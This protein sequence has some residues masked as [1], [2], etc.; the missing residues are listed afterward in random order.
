MKIA[1]KEL[2]F[3]NPTF[4]TAEIG[5]NHNGSVTLAKKLIDM[6]VDCGCD[7]VKF[8][9][10]TI[11]DV[12]SKEELIQGR[13]TPY[14][15]TN[16]DLKRH[17]EF[18]Y[19]DYVE[20]DKYCKKK[21]IIWFASP[22]DVKSVDF[23]EQ[24]DI[25]C[26]K[27]ASPCLTNYKLIERIKQTKKPV[28]LSTGMSTD[29]EIK[30]AFNQIVDTNDI[31]LCQCTSSYPTKYEEINLQYLLRLGIKCLYL[32]YSG[33]EKDI[34]PSILSVMMGACYIERHITLDKSMFGSDQ[35][36]SLE[37]KELADLAKSIRNIPVILGDGKSKVYESELSAKKKLR[38]E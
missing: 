19:D 33:H 14:G 10:R 13:F 26:Y 31:I 23:L 21:H 32:G 8:Q 17:L 38:R 15:T 5:I 7:A 35:S 28:I 4:I 6:A 1:N 29:N 3:K 18:N 11:E 22:W 36:V 30:K 24:F 12:Y 20:I 9:K 27:V 16:G 25:P 34:L 37:Y 2:G